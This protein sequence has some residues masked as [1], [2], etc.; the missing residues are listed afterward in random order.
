[1]DQRSSQEAKGC[2]AGQ[3]VLSS[4]RVIIGPP[5]VFLPTQTNPIQI[6]GTADYL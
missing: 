3:D 6:S 2:S 4:S 1:M 5:M